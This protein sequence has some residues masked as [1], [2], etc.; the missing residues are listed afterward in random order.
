MIDKPPEAH[1]LS[2]ITPMMAML[3][4]AAAALAG[5]ERN[6]ARLA[7]GALFAAPAA[8]YA[9]P[10]V[11]TLLHQNGWL[12][13]M[14]PGGSIDGLIGLAIGACVLRVLDMLPATF[15]WLRRRLGEAD[16]R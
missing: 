2:L 1:A 15:V 13:S 10:V 12:T 8:Y 9:P 11:V 14:P 5:K 7:G 16:A 4:L 6:M 3:G